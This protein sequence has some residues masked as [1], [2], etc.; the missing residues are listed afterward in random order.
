MKTLCRKLAEPIISKLLPNQ[1]YVDLGDIKSN[2]GLRSDRMESLTRTFILM[3]NYINLTHD[4]KVIDWYK[5]SILSSVNPKSYNYWGNPM[6]YSQNLV[7]V[8]NLVVGLWESK[9]FIWNTLTP[10]E[11][12]LIRDYLE[13][14]ISKEYIYNNWL[15]FKYIV[16]VF[17]GKDP[18]HTWSRINQFNIVEGWYY[19]RCG[20]LNSVDLYNCYSYHYFL[21]MALLMNPNLL[22]ANTIKDRL[23]KFCDDLT[24]CFNEN[25]SC[26]LAGC[27]KVYRFAIITPF[28][29][30]KRLGIQ[31]D[32]DKIIIENIAYW[33]TRNETFKNGILQA[34]IDDDY[35]EK[36]IS[37]AS[38][39]FAC[40]AFMDIKNNELRLLDS[41]NPA[42]VSY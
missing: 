34:K 12:Q 23:A 27:S 17:L 31:I 19:D 16:E 40:N 30:A 10:Q 35:I 9:E 39:Y 4:T 37:S 21:P 7:E 36:Y 24:V 25:G 29:L 11:R 18:N 1:T 26:I 20:Q 5:K 42:I 33:I 41:N 13:K 15:C 14:C 22:Q 3:S 8:A 32:A 6:N 28:I 2:H 38:P